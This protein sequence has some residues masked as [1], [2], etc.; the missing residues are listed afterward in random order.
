MQVLCQRLETAWKLFLNHAVYSFCELC[1]PIM[2]GRHGAGAR[3]AYRES[4]DRVTATSEEF[5]C[6]VSVRE[7]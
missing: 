5:V 3:V 6:F 2:C 1:G 4:A 7:P